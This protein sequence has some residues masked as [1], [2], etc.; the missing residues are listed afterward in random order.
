MH[1]NKPPRFM[2]VG[3]EEPIVEERY[4]EGNPDRTILTLPLITSVS[5]FGTASTEV[6][7]EVKLKADKLKDLLEFCD[8]P[9]SRQEMMTFCSIR[10]EKYF[11]EKIL[12][13]MLREGLILRTIPD[14][15]NSPKQRYIRQTVVGT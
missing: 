14:K 11:R 1:V 10:T 3:L 13:P 12:Q 4:G 6:S 9:R 2:Q 7:T 5:Y 8:V 15:P